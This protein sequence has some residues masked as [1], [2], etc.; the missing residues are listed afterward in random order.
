[1]VCIILILLILLVVPTEPKEYKVLTPRQVNG[2]IITYPNDMPAGTIQFRSMVSQRNLLGLE[3]ETPFGPATHKNGIPIALASQV[4]TIRILALKIEF[5]TEDPDEPTT[6]G[7]GNY[8]LRSL[9]QFIEDEGHDFDPAPHNTSY[10]SSHMEAL[11][12]Y[13]WF[14]SDKTLHLGWDVYPQEETLA[15]R[16]AHPMSY[17]G[18]ESSWGLDSIVVRLERFFKDAI[19]LVDTLAPEINFSE[20]K[21]VI[22]FHAGSDQQNNIA[23]IN[24]T[25]FDLWTGFIRLGEPLRV[26]SS[27]T[28]WTEVPDGLIVPETVS[29]DNRVGVINAVLAHE[30]GH[31]LGLI[32]LYNTYN[33][34]T[35]VGDF[36]LMDNNGL[37]VNVIFEDDGPFVTGVLPVYPDAWSRAYLG[38]SGVREIADGQ[39]IVISAAEQ[40][41]YDNEIVKVPISGMEYFLLE[42]RQRYADF[43]YIHYDPSIPNAII[44]DSATGVIL[45]PGWAYYDDNELYKVLTG[46]YDRLLPGDG[47]LIWHVDEAVAYMD[48]VGGGYNNFLQNTLQWDPNR[49]FVSVVEADGIIDLGDYNYF[50]GYGAD[51]DFFKVGNNIDFTPSTNPDTRSNLGADTHISITGITESDTLMYCDISIDWYQDGFPVMGFPKVGHDYGG[52]LALDIDTDGQNEILTGEGKFLIAVNPDGSPVTDSSFGLLIPNFDND[53]L[54]YIWP[55]FAIL[56]TNIAGNLIAGDFDGDD[57]L[58]VA[59]FD[60]ASK[61]YIFEYSPLD[62]LA[63]LLISETL[64]A[65]ITAGPVVFDID[66]DN[67]DELIVGLSDFSLH[68]INV[69]DVDT[70]NVTLLDN[71]DDIPTDIA[72]SDEMIFV[73]YGSSENF[74]LY[75]RNHDENGAGQQHTISLPDG[76]VAGIVCGDI[77][78][79]G[80]V[81]AAITVDDYLCIYNGQTG[82]IKTI[83]IESPGS[84]SLAD[85]NSDG[86]PEIIFTGGHDRVYVYN[87]LEVLFD[88]FPVRLSQSWSSVM[89]MTETVIA[90]V[91]ADNKPDIFICLPD[92]GL[93]CYN[94]HGDMLGGFP[95]ATS[96]RI[97]MVPLVNDIDGDGDIEVAAMD[98]AGFIAVWDIET[99]TDNINLPW[100]MA[101]GGIGHRCYLSP[102]FDKNILIAEG[103]LPEAEVYNY[104]NPAS[105]IT[106]FRYYVDRQAD[107]NVKIY[108]MS[109]ELVDKLK[110]S[111]PRGGVNEVPWNCSEF[112]SGVYFARLEASSPGVKKDV[113]VK[114]AL[115]K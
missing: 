37:S 4:D 84:P 34:Q 102:A 104:P 61:L 96:T 63:D 39:D 15:F 87:H 93:A 69:S 25:P 115:V 6:T 108:D 45:G 18:S 38:F 95:L 80:F 105:D 28:G 24:N 44:A 94:Y 42:N 106:Y 54:I 51:S 75:V 81:D 32:D 85:I 55:L 43:D 14:V 70:I 50:S 110:S 31:Q 76:Q 113:I 5:Q 79:D 65:S 8:D 114:V 16:L 48:Y 33:F 3:R 86:Y 29:Q 98:S 66:N 73:V 19:R 23:F 47:M 88:G 40:S 35:T 90:D 10:F 20:Y 89:Q 46:E 62:S 21:S 107:V 49:R 101:G 109:G 30:F 11:H 111:T 41:Y 56:D 92:G 17:Y 103:F 9:D 68:L 26:D 78:R 77:D 91:D 52:L 12:N 57:T 112:A 67:K 97:T 59:C 7:N 100:P 60:V 13:W 74:N 83:N 27:G 1:M 82:T 53:S 36:S 99:S 2:K 72:I 71:L 22:L 64:P 58:E